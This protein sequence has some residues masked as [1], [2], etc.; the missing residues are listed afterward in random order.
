MGGEAQQ[1]TVPASLDGARFDI[2]LAELAGLSRTRAR[3]LIESGEAGRLPTGQVTVARP[4][5]RIAAGDRVWFRP[6][7]EAALRP[8]PA[9]L[10]VRYEDPYLAVVNKP[11]GMVTHPG[12][13]NRDGT[14]VSVI[15]DRWPEVEGVGEYPRWGIVHRLD[16]D[17]SGVMVVARREV[18][19]RGL[20]AALAAR[21]V[22]RHY[23]ALVHGL[24]H[25]S[26]GTIEAPIDRRRARRFVGPGG[27]RA[28]THYRRLAS[29]T[30]PAISLLEVTLETGRTHQIRVHL[31]SIKRH[32]VGD[33]VYGKRGGPE[34]DPGRVWLH[35][36]RL[37]FAHPITGEDLDATAPLPQDLRSGLSALGTPTTGQWPPA[38]DHS[39]LTT[40]HRPLVR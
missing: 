14:L 6:A 36:H 12:P 20:T 17:T 33:P 31:E 8:R 28:V 23:L 22:H 1:V 24:F 37:R 18:A 30:R 39:P 5:T 29:W 11:P 19:Y 3:R 38:T 7:G 2:V 21:D 27:K 32:L 25:V 26:T 16:K 10:D 40:T 15:L 9:V 13:G 4:K 35:A 34:V